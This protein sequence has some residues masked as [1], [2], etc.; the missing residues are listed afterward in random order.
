MNKMAQIDTTI[1]L[2]VKDEPYASHVLNDILLILP[3]SMI[4]IAYSG[5][6]SDL[7]PY[8][9]KSKITFVKQKGNGKGNACIESFNLVQ[10]KFV[11]LVDS[12][13]T[14]NI[15]DLV[16]ARD[17]IRKGGDMVMGQRIAVSKEAM[18]NYIKFGNWA[19]T[20]IANILYGMHLKDSQTGLRII[21]TQ[22]LK[23]I[24]LTEQEFGIES[25]INIKM[26][27]KNYNIKE[28]PILYYN[29]EGSPSKQVKL[30]DGIKLFI[31]NFKFI[32]K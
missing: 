18:P 9:S 5:D 19:I 7:E 3:D 6:I 13:G 32:K 10:T 12:D 21:R 23:S 25:E 28:I 16:R 14:Y 27:K 24:K 22:A 4:I 15:F 30:I 20:K 29:R 1:I 31:L 8:R 2:P 17:L 11:G 26:H